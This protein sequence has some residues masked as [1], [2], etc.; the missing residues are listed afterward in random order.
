MK[1]AVHFK[2]V[3]KSQLQTIVS[4]KERIVVSEFARPVVFMEKVVV[5]LGLVSGFCR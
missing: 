4:V 5:A 1:V 3:G 2:I